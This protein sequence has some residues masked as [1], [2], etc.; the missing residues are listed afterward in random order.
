MG[1]NSK[2]GH[3]KFRIFIL[4]LI[5]AALLMVGY[6]LIGP[7]Q[8]EEE[9]C[10]LKCEKINKFWRLV[11]AFSNLPAKSGGYTGPFNCECY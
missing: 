1:T 3:L 2:M 8:T 7:H 4:S 5:A 9:A 10:R 6:S 11:P